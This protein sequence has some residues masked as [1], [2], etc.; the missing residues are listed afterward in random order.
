MLNSLRH[1]E[2]QILFAFFATV[3]VTFLTVAF[4]HEH[5]LVPLFN[6]TI[7]VVFGLFLY[8][9]RKVFPSLVSGFL[10]AHILMYLLLAQRE[11]PFALASG[12][13]F[14]LILIV[15]LMVGYTLARRFLPSD[16]EHDM[17]F[18]HGVH[19]YLIAL[20]MGLLAASTASFIYH[21]LGS[22]GVNFTEIFLTVG[23]SHFLSLS[24]IAPLVYF[25][26][27]A[28]T[29]KKPLNEMMI[30]AG[31][32]LLFVAALLFSFQDASTFVFFRHNYILVVFFIIAAVKFS[33]LTQLIMMAALILIG[34][35]WHVDSSASLGSF[36]IETYTL[37]GLAHVSVILSLIIKWFLDTQN[38]AH[39]SLESTN[40]N[41]D[42]TLSYTQTILQLSK[43]IVSEK[44]G[45]ESLSEKTFSLIQNVFDDADAH[46]SYLVRQ[47][48][49]THFGSNLYEE[50]SIP[51]L[52]ELHDEKIMKNE[53]VHVIEDVFKQL[54][55]TY[56]RPYVNLQREKAVLKARIYLTFKFSQKE[57]MVVGLDYHRPLQIHKRDRESIN[58]MRQITTLLNR[59]FAKHFSL[60][61]SLKLK[62]DIVLALARTLDLYDKYTKG[63]SETVAN[64]ASRVGKALGVGTN[65]LEDLYWAG[66]LHDIGKLGVKHD[67][68]NSKDRLSDEEYKE[69]KKHVDKGYGVLNDSDALKKASKMMRDHHERVD[70]KGYPQ[71]LRDEDISLGGKILSVADA[72]ATMSS[73]RPYQPR[74]SDG[75]IIKEL[76]RCKGTQFS[77]DVTDAAIRLIREGEL[78]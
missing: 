37:I 16:F 65:E 25:S 29:E 66:I 52:Y 8:Y 22:N 40:R 73:D 23:F 38:R 63:H 1:S 51:W 7:G 55:D 67:V 34:I 58:R 21:F 19:F 74:K 31:F 13:V 12:F 61:Q 24:T 46:F 77:A 10:I 28:Y 33:F 18:K 60:R 27:P 43:D 62:K 30:C 49:F 41:L 44:T 57:W 36:Y 50:D 26:S 3:G 78:I 71:G 68:L 15:E 56:G 47:G 20:L 32:V 5:S 70:G 64:I 72:I 42:T 76:H 48:V 6:P 59:L 2:L 17:R 69:I 9:G 39:A 11:V 14:S 35:F 53:T 75:D 45:E 4:L 54:E